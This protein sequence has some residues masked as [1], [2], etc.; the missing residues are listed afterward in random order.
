M[1][2]HHLRVVGEQNVAGANIVFAP[3]R[4]LG[5]DPLMTDAMVIRHRE[6]GAI[7]KDESV[8]EAIDQGRDALLKAVSEAKGRK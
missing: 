1:A 7:G 3:M 6:M 5:L 4:E 8:R 2:A